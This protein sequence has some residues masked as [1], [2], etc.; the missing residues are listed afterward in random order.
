MFNQITTNYLNS[1]NNNQKKLDKSKYQRYDLA[2]GAFPPSDIVVNALSMFNWQ[3]LSTLPDKTSTLVKAALTDFLK[4]SEDNIAVFSGADEII[5]ILPRMYISPG[6]SVIV[7]TPTFDRLIKTN[8]KNGGKVIT[9]SLEKSKNFKLDNGAKE[10][11]GGLIKECSPKLVWICSPN[12]PTGGVVTVQTIADLASSYPETVF[13]I[14]EA[15]Q[16]YFS[17]DPKDSA[18][19]LVTTNPNIVVIRSFSKAFGLA[20]VRIGYL[21]SSSLIVSAVRKYQTMFGVSTVANKLATVALS[22]IDHVKKHVDF[23]RAQRVE[24]ERAIN[25]NPNLEC[26]V[27][28]QTNFILIRHKNKD[29]FEI[30]LQNN[31]VSSDWSMTQGIE[32]MRYVR[33][34]IGQETENDKLKTFLE[35]VD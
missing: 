11:L 34:S 12:N 9:F 4:L 20:G 23:I 29:L 21:V 35:K 28:S 22:D 19:S 33:I 13:V 15:Y 5:E 24:L 18:V 1:I 31:M 3:E 25:T 17:L 30:L 27:G 32:N 2:E 16:E 7:V 26:V 10:N 8:Q 6:D 14:D